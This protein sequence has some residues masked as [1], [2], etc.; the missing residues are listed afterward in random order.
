M[1]S[2]PYLP[3]SA[4]VTGSTREAVAAFA[5]HP[6]IDS[7]TTARALVRDYRH[8]IPAIGALLTNSPQ[9]PNQR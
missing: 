5:L 8:A 7:V 3:I 2:C 1:A 4:A 9:N 6:L